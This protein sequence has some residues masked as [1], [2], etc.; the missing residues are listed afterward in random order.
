[1]AA[2]LQAAALQVVL[3]FNDRDEMRRQKIL[4]DEEVDYHLANAKLILK[5][6]QGSPA[7]EGAKKKKLSAS[8][9]GYGDTDVSFVPDQVGASPAKKGGKK[10]D[11]GGLKEPVKVKLGGPSKAASKL[12]VR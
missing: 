3:L 6:Q 9:D 4:F 5:I 7:Q 2:A 12:C 1:M 11:Y 10:I 8:G